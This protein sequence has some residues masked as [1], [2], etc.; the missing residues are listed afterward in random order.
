MNTMTDLNA[1]NKVESDAENTVEKWLALAL[2]HIYAKEW[3]EAQNAC[4]CALRCNGQHAEAHHLAGHVAGQMGHNDEA[5]AYLVKA[6]D[7]DPRHPQYR[8]NYAV[9]LGLLGRENE[10]AVQYQ[11]CLRQDPNHRDALWN[12]G[13]MLRLAEH[14]DLAAKLLQR[15][16]ALGGNYRALHHRLGVVYSALRQDKEADAHFLKEL[17]APEHTDALTNWEYSLFLLSRERFGEGF[18]H[19]SR[20]FQ[21]GGRNSV[22]CHAFNVPFW[23]GGFTKNSTLL[24]HGEQGLGDEMMFASVVPEVLAAAQLMNSR[25]V[26]AVKPPLV[27]LFRASFPAAQVIPHKVGGPVADLS[28]MGKI[29]WQIAMGDLPAM[30]RFKL[31]DFKAASHAYLHADPART[32]WY[33]NQLDALNAPNDAL[34]SAQAFAPA[35]PKLRV[36]L[37]WGS[38]P[39]PINAKFMRWSQQRSIPI[40]VFERLASFLPQVQF[41]SLQN[42]ER[43]HE[44]ALAPRLDILDLSH[45]QTDFLETASLIANL[46]LVISVDTSVSHLAGAMGKETWVPLIKR[47]DWRHGNQRNNSYWYAHTRYFHQEQDGDWTLVME[48]MAQALTERLAQRFP[49]NSVINVAKSNAQTNAA[50]PSDMPANADLAQAVALLGQRDFDAARPYFEKALAENSQDPRVQWEFA[51]QLLTEEKWA[52]GWDFHEARFQIFGAQGLNLCPLPWP[53]WQGEPLAGRSIVVH[54]EQGIGDE[55]M[56]ASM[57]PDLLQMGARVIIACVPSLVAIFQYSFPT[58]LVVAHARG[59]SQNW[60][61]ALP[62]WTKSKMLGPVDF[63]ISIASLGQFVRRNAGDFPRQAYLRTEPERVAKMARRL[64]DTAGLSAKPKSSLPMRIGLAWCGSLGDDNARARSIPLRNMEALIEVGKSRGWQFVS[65]QSRQYARQAAEVPEFGIIDMSE[66]TDDFADLAALM[67]NLDLIISVDTSY[68]HLAG[69]LGL[70]TWRLV[71]RSCDWRWGW[72]RDDSVWYP[73]DKLFRQKIDGDWA[74]AIQKIA[75]ELKNIT[76]LLPI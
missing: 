39:A 69:A 75:S 46:D 5:L 61:Q 6:I 35:L 10:A 41:V 76:G 17:S 25:V 13:E 23:N 64:K 16:A 51:M 72:E 12:Y 38:N 9:S 31:Q 37:M 18:A 11:A 63:Q 70:T 21:A 55:I 15:F 2:K 54:G 28:E 26:L 57:V 50:A 53:V 3:L 43:G 48:A 42:A 24:I 30:F 8:Y 56:Y 47:S 74:P 29:D 1:F 65:L 67:S 32:V 73:N 58:A 20:R 68:G 34:S 62:L 45:L 59:S 4:A 44:A 36:G 19:Y 71:T 60:D 27:R 66:H 52:R 22:Y 33:A 40:Q 7:L 49:A 14:F